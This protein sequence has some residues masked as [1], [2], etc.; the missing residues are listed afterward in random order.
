MLQ[1]QNTSRRCTRPGEAGTYLALPELGAIP[2][3][4]AWTAIA[5][6]FL[7]SRNGKLRVERAVLEQAS[8]CVSE[9][10]RSTLASILS[11]RH[12]DEIPTCW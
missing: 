7:H 6:G 8:S 11:A 4:G 1:E 9:S 5:L 3:D 2:N 10:F 12:G